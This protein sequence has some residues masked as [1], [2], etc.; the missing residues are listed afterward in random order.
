M[1]F[2]IASASIPSGAIITG[3]S[4]TLEMTNTS[5]AAGAQVMNLHSLTKDFGEGTSNANGGAGAGPG[6]GAA[7]TTG[8]ATWFFNNYT[9]SSW[10]TQGGDFNSASSAAQT[11]DGVGSYS[12]SYS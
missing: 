6:V 1:Q 12:W 9:S 10:T 11:V 3:A 2:D 7:A 8:D 4:L 5:G